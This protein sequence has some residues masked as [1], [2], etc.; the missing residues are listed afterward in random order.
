MQPSSSHRGDIQGLRALAVLLVAFGHAG[1]GFLPG[2]FVGV[3]VFFVL[4]GF[5]ITGLLIS[6]A[7]ANGSI[8]LGAFYRRRARRILPAAVLTLLV[9]EA[10][11]FF[12]LNFVRAKEAMWDSIFAAVFL[13]NFRFAEQET[14]YFAQAQPPSP[15]LH[16]WSLGVEEQF[17]LVWPA[18]ISVVLLGAA[19]LRGGRSIRR[20]DLRV[21]LLVL[22]VAGCASLVWS[23]HRT[24]TLPPVAYFSPFTRAWELVLGA[25]LAVGATTLGRVRRGWKL[26]AGWSGLLAIGAS[27]VLF[28]SETPF[29]G[30]AALLPTVGAAL[31]IC[32][33]MTDTHPRAAAAR[34]LDRAPLRFVGDR[35]YAFYLWHWPVLIIAQQYLGYEPPLAVNLALL[36]G[37]FLLS[38]ASYALVEN[39]LRRK[40]WSGPTSGLVFGAAAAT[41][42]GAAV[43]SIGALQGQEARFS[44][45]A[46]AESEFVTP[47][48]IAAS[49]RTKKRL[50]P[51]AASPA[52]PAV[53]AAVEAA[54]R[55][56]PIPSPLTPPIRELLD[57]RLPYSLPPGCVPVAR[58]SETSSK[59]CPLGRTESPRSIVVIGD[60]H[61]QMWLSPI[62]TMARRDGWVV[63]PILR[64]GCLPSSWV[65]NF[66]AAFCK[67]WYRWAI[68]Q[69]QRLR[70]DMTIVGGAVGGFRGAEAWAAERGMLAMGRAVERSSGKVVV[71]GD[72]E[73]LKRNPIDCLLSRGA[74]M[75]RCTATW[76]PAMLGPYN[77]IAVRSRRAGLGFLDTRG[78]FCFERMCP[79]VIGR[80]IAYKD[81]HHITSAYALRLTAVLRAALRRETR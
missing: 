12:L 11:A 32:A 73:G 63:L 29:P 50:A 30:S 56:R 49:Y 36:S 16:L 78:W 35:S 8:S 37:A 43:L 26:A 72:P 70:P 74:S 22:A 23:V 66:R 31:V 21:L 71:V 51:S 53:V 58:S 5:L 38:I 65:A 80:T 10:A 24:A 64:P 42:I 55:G 59:I 28:S 57:E 13:A 17:Y 19:A 40:N 48:P 77:R 9:T 62:V 60:S 76:A 69:V 2:G 6:E 54:R 27:A 18:L 20:T 52:L 75:A 44:V 41:V 67:T 4:S 45:A 33:G 47:V 34:L 81:P 79:A 46:A 7:Q 3:D 14:D 68:E 1:L 15:L 61:A 25:G 39:P